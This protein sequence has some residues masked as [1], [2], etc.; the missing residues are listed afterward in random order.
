MKEWA[1]ATWAASS[2]SSRVASGLP[3]SMFSLM[4]VANKAGSWLTS[5]ICCLS[6]LSFNALMSCP[7]NR[8]CPA[9]LPFIN[10]DFPS[11]QTFQQTHDVHETR[12]INN[13]KQQ[14]QCTHYSI[15]LI[16]PLYYPIDQLPFIL[17]GI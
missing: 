2:I 12:T 3:N 6:H 7:S 1:L 10:R 8:T 11:S 16:V 13:F 15:N 9:Q 4:V 14:R 5:P 17:T